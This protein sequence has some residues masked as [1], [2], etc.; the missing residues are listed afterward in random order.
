MKNYIGKYVCV[1][2]G[3]GDCIL[4]VFKVEIQTQTKIGFINNYGRQLFSIKHLIIVSDFEN[5]CLEIKSK[6]KAIDDRRWRLEKERR[7]YIEAH[8]NK[9]LNNPINI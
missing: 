6:I 2:S 9:L 1:S 3:V 8:R 4:Y 5:E 7:E